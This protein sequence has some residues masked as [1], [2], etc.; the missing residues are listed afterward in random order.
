VAPTGVDLYKPEKAGG[1]G[2]LTGIDALM[3]YDAQH[4]WPHQQIHKNGAQQSLCPALVRAQGYTHDAKY[5]EAQERFECKP[6]ALTI[7]ESKAFAG[8]VR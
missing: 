8:P 6:T 4:P 3:Q 5:A 1:P 7:L 2:I